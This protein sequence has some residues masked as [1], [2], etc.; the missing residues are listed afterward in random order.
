MPFTSVNIWI[1]V[2]ID[3]ITNINNTTLY[4]YKDLKY[5]IRTTHTKQKKIKTTGT[6]AA[7]IIV[8]CIDCDS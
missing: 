2:I 6:T 7:K 5:I 4:H 1:W 8:L 3:V